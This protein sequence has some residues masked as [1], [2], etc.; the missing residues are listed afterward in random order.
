MSTGLKRGSE[1]TNE[2]RMEIIVGS[3]VSIAWL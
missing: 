3:A 2:N 1:V